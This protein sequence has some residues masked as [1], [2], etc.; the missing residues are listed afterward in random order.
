VLHPAHNKLA[1][2]HVSHNEQTHCFCKLSHKSVH[3]IWLP[4]CPT[5]CYCAS[6]TRKVRSLA[7]CRR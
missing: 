6:A 5:R 1:L 7:V 4:Q 2:P 3:M